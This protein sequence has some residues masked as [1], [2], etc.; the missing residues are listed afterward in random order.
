MGNLLISLCLFC[1]LFGLG[2]CRD[3]FGLW[4]I[5]MCCCLI[6]CWMFLKDGDVFVV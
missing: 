1:Y 2:F 6:I 4:M 3:R 5:L